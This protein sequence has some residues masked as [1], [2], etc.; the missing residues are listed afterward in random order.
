MT[1]SEAK[2][3]SADDYATNARF[4]ADLAGPA[5]LALLDAQPGEKILDLGCGDGALTEKIVATGADV[6]GVDGDGDMIRAAKALGLDA[7]V[8]DGQAL[9]FGPEFDG[10]FTNAALHWM[11]QP[12]RVAAGVFAAL[13]PGGRYVGEFGGFANIASIQAGARAVMALNGYDVPPGL[14]HYYPTPD[15]YAALLRGAGFVDIEA[16]LIPRPTFLPTGLKG[17]LETF[18]DSL[19][20][21]VPAAQHA[22]MID[23]ICAFLKPIL[24]TPNGQWFGDYIRLRFSAYKPAA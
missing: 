15:D 9:T 20:P 16:Q 4:V 18:G 13:K 17:W 14:P 21:G 10:V 11:T 7:H 5:M 1:Q 12:Q 2:T 19:L 23:E 22:S 6:V 8:M 24:S 3:W